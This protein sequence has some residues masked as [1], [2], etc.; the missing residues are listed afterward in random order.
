MALIFEFRV[1][2]PLLPLH[3]VLMSFHIPL[4]I[5]YDQIQER[6]GDTGKVFLFFLLA[7]YAHNSEIRNMSHLIGVETLLLTCT[8]TAHIESGSSNQ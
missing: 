4:S 6:G 7:T 8:R 5:R 3:K 1:D 2:L